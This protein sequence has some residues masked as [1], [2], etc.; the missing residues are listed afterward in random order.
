M[1]DRLL[2]IA[3]LPLLAAC[4]APP[5][6]PATPPPVVSVI[7]HSTFDPRQWLRGQG[8]AVGDRVITAA[9]V[10]TRS[11]ADRVPRSLRV[12]GVDVGIRSPMHGDLRAVDALYKS[13]TMSSP[14]ALAEDWFCFEVA[15]PHALTDLGL[16]FD[17]PAPTPGE[18]LFAVR[19]DA[20][21]DA[22]AYSFRELKVA[23]HDPER[24]PLPERLL[25]VRSPGNEELPGWSGC[26]VGRYVPSRTPAWEFVGILVGEVE[27]PGGDARIVVVRPPG[28]AVTW[29]RGS[30]PD[31]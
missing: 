4:A 13:G 3:T 20:E 8:I 31:R 27:L 5:A 2:V 28:E 7:A 25:L 16:W 6:P 10:I 17:G 15:I 14:E 26:F 19:L 23:E 24:T 30:G 12:N 18:S 9:H 11:S 21:H 22:D 1:I 29:L